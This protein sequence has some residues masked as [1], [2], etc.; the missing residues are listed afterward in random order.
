MASGGGQEVAV[1]A[2][3]IC[4]PECFRILVCWEGQTSLRVCRM[5]GSCACVP[6]RFTIVGQVLQV[7]MS[8][9][10]MCH[11]TD[12]WW[13][14]GCV[15]QGWCRPHLDLLLSGGSKVAGRREVIWLMLVSG[16]YLN[17]RGCC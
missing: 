8:D 9:D 6:Q 4:R 13:L 12:M 2:E 15:L 7:S 17:S 16:V 1:Q 11:N 14:F 10:N 5:G 3:H